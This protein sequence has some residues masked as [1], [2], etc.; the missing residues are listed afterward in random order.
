MQ[1]LLRDNALDFM[2]L[3]MN[4]EFYHTNAS[5]IQCN[6]IL[7]AFRTDRKQKQIRKM[8]GLKFN[9][10]VPLSAWAVKLVHEKGDLEGPLEG[11]LEGLG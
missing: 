8:D 7:N 10:D 1:F 6:Q 9:R 5:F 4:L 11:A 2:S 3:Q